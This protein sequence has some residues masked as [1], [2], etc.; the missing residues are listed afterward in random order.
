MEQA[1]KVPEMQIP[2]DLREEYESAKWRVQDHG[3]PG[4]RHKMALI[5]RIAQLEAQVARLSG[6]LVNIRNGVRLMVPEPQ[7]SAFVLLVDEALLDAPARKEAEKPHRCQCAIE[8]WRDMPLAG[9][10]PACGGSIGMARKEELCEDEG[11]PHFGTPHVCISKSA[12][13]EGAQQ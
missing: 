12:R 7:Q 6:A 2:E 8:D 11:C 4:G 3:S 9:T 1:A 5:E 13:K 10:C